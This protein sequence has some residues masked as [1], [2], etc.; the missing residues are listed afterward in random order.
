MRSIKRY[1]PPLLGLSWFVTFLLGM[2]FPKL[3]RNLGFIKGPKPFMDLQSVLVFG[4]CLS[5][6]ETSLTTAKL[7]SG[8]CDPWNRPYTYPLWI[9]HLVHFL[10]LSNSQVNLIG[11]LNAILLAISI[12]IIANYAGGNR[13][14]FA[15]A[16]FSPPMFFLAERGNIDSVI[17]FL[18]LLF[19]YGEARKNRAW[20]TWIPGLLV[21]TKI[22]PLG[23][24]VTFNKRR[25]LALGIIFTVLFT[26]LWIGQISSVLGNQ[27]HSRAWS[28]G[29]IILVT[30]DINRLYQIGS[31]NFKITLLVAIK[32]IEIWF[33][34]YFAAKVL[35]QRKL[36]ELIAELKNSKATSTILF[37]GA[38]IFL[39]SYLGFSVSD[40]KLWTGLLIAAGLARISD[41]LNKQV[42]FTLLALLLVGMWGSRFVPHWME[43]VGDTSLLLLSCGLF[44]MTFEYVRVN[45]YRPAQFTKEYKG[46]DF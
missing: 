20:H 40:Y 44:V 21:A 22:Y 8:V 14:W 43:Y 12:G 19:I 27:P 33:G 32:M 25:T 29:D 13:I 17:F 35:A 42:K 5:R 28:Y 46:P 16:V 9:A 38:A 15:L 4:D 23:L 45:L 30:S 37:S 3:A 34:C 26:P 39:F 6:P 7:L 36:S 2:H 11:W 41:S 18:V 1:V 10:H 24:L 31:I